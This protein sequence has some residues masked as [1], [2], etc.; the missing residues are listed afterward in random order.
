VRLRQRRVVFFSLFGIWRLPR[1]SRPD[2]HGHFVFRHLTPGAWVL[3]LQSRGKRVETT[4]P[5]GTTDVR[6]VQ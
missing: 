4:V 5:T 6:L 2:E 1:P 3:R